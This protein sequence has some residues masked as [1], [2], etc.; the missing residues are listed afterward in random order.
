VGERSNGAPPE[1]APESPKHVLDTLEDLSGE[2][3]DPRI[4]SAITQPISLD[5]LRRKK[6]MMPAV[7]VSRK[8]SKRRP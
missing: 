4:E 5:E 3:T 7:L 8:R 2:K 1:P 6:R